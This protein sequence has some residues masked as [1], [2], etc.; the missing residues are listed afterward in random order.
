MQVSTAVKPLGTTAKVNL[1][2]EG[3]GEVYGFVAF[4]LVDASGVLGQRDKVNDKF[5]QSS[6]CENARSA[7]EGGWMDD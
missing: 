3:E 4:S 5:V 1:K 2:G 7:S 6:E